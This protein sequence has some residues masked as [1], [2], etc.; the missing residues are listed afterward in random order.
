VEAASKHVELVAVKMTSLE[1]KHQ[2]SEELRHAQS[3]ELASLRNEQSMGE[4]NV[5]EC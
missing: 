1:N 2:A 5:T 4:V 3:T